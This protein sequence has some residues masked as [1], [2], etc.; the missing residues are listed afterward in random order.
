MSQEPL[1]GL[2]AADYAV[3]GV[4]LGISAVIGIYF[5][6]KDRRLQDGMEG[7]MLGGRYVR[8][9]KLTNCSFLRLK[10]NLSEDYV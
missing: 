9:I 6:Y 8:T 10:V 7:Y 3:F 5:A 4:T 2:T 1:S